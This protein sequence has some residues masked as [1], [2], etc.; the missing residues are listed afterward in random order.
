MSLIKIKFC[1]NQEIDFK[2]KIKHTILKNS[3]NLR[4]LHS[5]VLN[6]NINFNLCS[7]VTFN[8]PKR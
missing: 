7:I 5:E 2:Y 8:S 6:Q 4:F 1:S 3:E